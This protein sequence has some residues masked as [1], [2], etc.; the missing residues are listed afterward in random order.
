[1][2]AGET[3]SEG[4][5]IGHVCWILTNKEIYAILKKNPL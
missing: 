2:R 4:I 1:M 3:A 5:Y